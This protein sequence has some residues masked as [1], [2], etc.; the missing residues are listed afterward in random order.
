[1]IVI[2][3]ALVLV[4]LV[5]LVIGVVQ[6]T[7]PFVYASIAVSLVSLVFLVIGILQRR[8]ETAPSGESEAKEPAPAA[9]A[10]NVTA[11][12]PAQPSRRVRPSEQE[13]S[14]EA[15]AA[16]PDAPLEDTSDE[17]L[18]YGGTVLVVAGR[19]RYHVDGC[20]YLTGK[21]AEEV[22][23]L[24]AR[25]EGFTPCGVCKPD[26]ALAEQDELDD[27]EADDQD[28]VEDD[29]PG[30]EVPPARRSAAA[31]TRAVKSTSTPAKS[32]P[33]KNAPAKSAP[34]KNAP[35]KSAPAKSA[36]AK[37]A[38]AAKKAP[39]VKTPGK[40]AVVKAPG[41]A[42]VA[43]AAGPTASAAAKRPGS[44]V[45]LPDRGKFHTAQC[46]FVRGVDGTEVLTK[47]VASRQGYTACG[48]CKP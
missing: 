17:E 4:A 39:A 28:V 36:P 27:D 38:K 25:E 46:R 35:A 9:D 16:E 31:G 30:I 41:T 15:V 22:D 8:G 5:L 42:A 7:L 1:M 43:A 44:V 11:V 13:A 24:D 12:I 6:Q 18:D 19:P 2:S 14:P 20:R 10:N 47:T 34:A 45:V 29:V 40:A 48:V 21:T 23:V 32:A 37:A 3:G 26:D 33:A